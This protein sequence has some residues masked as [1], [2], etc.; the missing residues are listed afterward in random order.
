MSNNKLLITTAFAPIIWGS[1]YIVTTQYLPQD[2]PLTLAML[3]ALPVGILLL[4]LVR[5]LPSV[6][7]L[8]KIGV[9]GAL[10][11]S[12]FWWLLFVSA[13]LLP[14]GVA[15]TLGAMQPLLVLFL[16]RL[17]LGTHIQLAAIFTL[18]LGI[19]GVAILLLSA[20]LALDPIGILAGFGAT[21]S[22]GLGTVLSKKWYGANHQS[23]PDF[24][25]V[26][27]LTLTAWQLSAGGLILLPAAMLL[28]P[29][30]PT[31]SSVNLFA[32]GYLGLIGA[33]LTYYLWFRG[34]A[35]LSPNIISPL[36]FLSPLS[37]VI[38]GW[39]VLDQSLTPLQF[40]GAAIII[41][42][43]WLSQ[44]AMLKSLSD[45]FKR[46]ANLNQLIAKNTIINGEKL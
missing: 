42:S 10:N 3:R 32:F 46:I 33:G 15:A 23:E 29:A 9:L 2:Y 44:P 16:S 5:Q 11:F 4:V 39:L 43:V 6:N 27:P 24:V 20:Q 45:S 21:I 13:Y 38:L 8:L 40:G 1:S 12:F 37:A 25:A 19:I 17:L 31:L 18:L 30:L 28:E 35:A 41:A 36:A 7:E 34:I 26:S 14:G 22:M